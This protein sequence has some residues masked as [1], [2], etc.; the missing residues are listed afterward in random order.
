MLPL[1]CYAIVQWEKDKKTQS[2]HFV[3]SLLLLKAT[4]SRLDVGPA[5]YKYPISNNPMYTKK[6]FLSPEVEI[7]KLC[8]STYIVSPPLCVQGKPM[9]KSMD[10]ESHIHTGTSND[11]FCPASWQSSNFTC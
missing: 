11:L 7:F 10:I 6:N 4:L 8:A 2:L 3:F 1:L 9:T 5:N